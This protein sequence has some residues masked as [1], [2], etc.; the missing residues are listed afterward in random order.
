[1]WS[2]AAFSITFQK[3]SPTKSEEKKENCFNKNGKRERGKKVF[4]VFA[5]PTGISFFSFSATYG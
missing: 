2:R 5:P 3:R 1:M 4:G